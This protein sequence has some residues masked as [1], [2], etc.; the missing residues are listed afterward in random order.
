MKLLKIF[1][2]LTIASALLS[3]AVACQ[4][5]KFE[6]PFDFSKSDA[7]AN[8]S[9]SISVPKMDVKSRA[10]LSDENAN[11]VT[12]L[13]VRIYNSNT[14][15]AT[16]DAIIPEGVSEN[17]TH[18]KFTLDPIKTKSGSSFIVA[19]AN[20]DVP[21]RK[22]NADGTYTE[23]TLRDLL[24]TAD[25][26]A[27]FCA[28]SVKTHTFNNTPSATV[29]LENLPMCG[30]YYAGAIAH[31]RNMNWD[32]LNDTPFFIPVTQDRV[33]TLPGT[34]HLRRLVSYVKFNLIPGSKTGQPKVKLVP[35]S[36]RVINAPLDSWMFE[37]SGKADS[38]IPAQ[39]NKANVGEMT[40][41]SQSE[42]AQGYF[43]DIFTNANFYDGPSDGSYSFD[44]W[45]MENKHTG[46][47]ANYNDREKETKV[48]ADGEILPSDATSGANSGIYT[49]LCPDGKWTNNNDASMVEIRCRVEPANLT[50]VAGATSENTFGTAVINVHLG[51]INNV[52]SDFNCRRNTKYTYNI[53]INGVNEIYVEA[54]SATLGAETR[55]GLEGSVTQVEE[56]NTNLDAHYG[57]INIQLSDNERLSSDFGYIIEAWENGNIHSF[58]ESSTFT[59]E[60]A[61]LRKY[62][63]WVE[64]IPT[65]SQ[66]VLAP[67]N[68]DNVIKIDQMGA[69]KADGTLQYPHTQT[70]GNGDTQR[71]YT[72][73]VNEYVYETSANETGN[74]WQGYVNQP[75]RVCWIKTRQQE[76]P[77]G[78]SIYITS[79]YAFSQRSIQTYYDL[80][81]STTIG[82]V[83]TE[84]VNESRGLNL[85][86]QYPGT[87]GIDGGTLNSSNGRYN[88]YQY[89]TNTSATN[90]T[91]VNSQ[92]NNVVNRAAMQTI[93]AVNAQGANYP[94]HTATQNVLHVPALV[95][96]ITVD[97]LTN[98]YNPYAVNG[99]W[100]RGTN[101]YDPQPGLTIN[102]SNRNQFMEAMNAC[103]NRNRDNNG[104]GQIDADEVR[105]YVPATAK[106]VRV[107]LGRNS[108]TSP[109]MDYKSITEKLYYPTSGEQIAHGE[110]DKNTR[111]KMFT[112]TR[113]VIW[114]FE[115]LSLSQMGNDWTYGYWEVR[116]VRNLGTNLSNMP[117]GDNDGTQKAFVYTAADRTFKMTYYDPLSIR[118]TI[119][120]GTIPLHF[121]NNTKIIGG[122]LTNVN[123][124]MCATAFEFAESDKDILYS[125]TDE[126]GSTVH[127][128]NSYD[129]I[130]EWIEGNPCKALNEENSGNGYL[131]HTNWRVPNQKEMAIIRNEANETITRSGLYYLTCTQEYFD[132]DG[133]I[134]EGSHL[135]TERRVIAIEKTQSVAFS[136]LAPDGAYKRFPACVRCVRDK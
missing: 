126:D 108:L 133:Y 119:S 45:Q 111:Y 110:K 44:F 30:I 68:P 8:V 67:Y 123:Y 12:S 104:N 20:I 18:E 14:G 37:R 85:R 102:E 79:K 50:G 62:I 84:H 94:A 15:E 49:A 19:V 80:D 86:S 77:D 109:I 83:G 41:K 118:P 36:Y 39:F 1:A 57:V 90:A 73:H 89:L 60:N 51:Y 134:P 43:S 64:F 59:G 76:S 4:D 33:Y 93:N 9:L 26:W 21:A 72:V 117:T 38:Y 34:I 65:T 25:T 53:T 46:T 103:T 75:P 13:W 7:P 107:I 81:N 58:D 122:T 56:I 120:Y 87:Y 115:G 100:K 42:V 70:N 22:Y 55:P 54:T 66:T 132:R 48:N 136:V 61:T 23:G 69:K 128:F 2:N 96:T 116:C 98:F 6:P 82:A 112:S 71:W 130:L 63:D 11:R 31:D 129:D 97:G 95:N 52:A 27:D 28:I 32:E 24:A 99:S 121:V 92:W 35:M 106:C 113:Q 91:A 3:G 17:Q 135:N 74:T 10:D 124:N 47:A 5:D 114:P 88:V 29:P 40:V 127:W 16:S 125:R 131:G 101:D 78:E 105:W